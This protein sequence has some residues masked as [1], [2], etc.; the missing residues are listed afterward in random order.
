MQ[1]CAH[2]Y[3]QTC[4]RTCTLQCMLSH[5][6]AVLHTQT[7]TTICYLTEMRFCTHTHTHTHTLTHQP[8]AQLFLPVCL[9]SLSPFLCLLSPPTLSLSLSLWAGW[10]WG[11][12][13]CHVFGIGAT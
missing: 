4:A 5:R 8:V 3:T 6:N 9:L 12:A 10:A 13:T 11:S 2:T 7:H 1:L